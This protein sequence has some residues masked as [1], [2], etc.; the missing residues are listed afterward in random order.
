[1]ELILREKGIEEKVKVRWEELPKMIEAINP[2]RNI[3]VSQN[4]TF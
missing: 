1:M 4:I 2:L 3:L